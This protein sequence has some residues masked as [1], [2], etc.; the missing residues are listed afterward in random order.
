MFIESRTPLWDNLQY[1]KL[2]NH[3]QILNLK[4]R[5]AHSSFTELHH[6]TPTFVSVNGSSDQEI[7]L[8]DPDLKNCTA[9]VSFAFSR[10]SEIDLAHQP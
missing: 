8:N 2:D 3:L 10:N 4:F 9:K 5:V 7:R 1:L 6:D